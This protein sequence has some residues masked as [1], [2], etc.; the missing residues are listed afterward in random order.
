MDKEYKTDPA[1][2]VKYLFF[3]QD[4]KGIKPVMGDMA[5]VRIVYK[6]EKD[7]LLFDSHINGRPDSTSIIPLTLKSIFSG[8][9]EQ[10][11]TLMAKGDSA[12][13]LISADS[14]YL[15]LFKQKALPP[16]IK[17]GSKLKFYIKLVKI[18]TPDQ[19]K[20]REYGIILQRRAD[21]EKMKNAEADSIRR[22][23]TMENIQ[24]KPTMIDSL[25]I[26]E[27]KGTPGRPINEGDS[28]ELKY[29][30]MFLNGKI[31]DQSDRG[32]G[33]PGTFKILYR[34]NAKLITGWLDLLET[35]HQ[36]ETV[37]VLIPSSLAYGS[38]GAGK[39]IKPFTPLLFEIKVIK[40][41]S[42]FEQ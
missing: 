5:Y 22:Y 42:P 10:G 31:F 20:A 18:E 41:S 4:K 2:G 26:L 3:K 25:Y 39:D 13:F 37:R 33:G 7:S 6:T 9:L 15:K 21:M 27:R 32:D 16:Y 40:V 12:S 36:G 1:T 8:S 29:T 23:L 35:L 34:H 30:G 28:V 17:Q 38:Y 24:V 19:L 11:I 14:V